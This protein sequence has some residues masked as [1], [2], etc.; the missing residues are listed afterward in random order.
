LTPAGRVKPGQ[1]KMDS[2]SAPPSLEDIRR[3]IDRIDDAVLKLIGER[4][5]MVDRVRAAKKES[6]DGRSS[7]MRPGREA[8]ILKRL[9]EASKDEI[10]A[11][12][13]FTVWRALISAATQK[14]APVRVHGPAG[15]LASASAHFMVREYFGSAGLITHADEEAAFAALADHPSDVAAMITDGPWLT[16]FL[17]GLAGKAQVIGCLPFL[18]PEPTPRVLIFG[19]STPEP[20]GDD[21]TLVVTDG[22]VPRDFAPAPLWQIE[23]G[24]KRL[25]SLPGFLSE[26]NMPLIN[27]QRSNSRLA[28]TVVG[29]YPSPIEVKS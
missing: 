2:P 12:V 7:P 24:G 3:E 17:K 27:L 6:E 20:T 28:L 5:A 13:C 29:R 10:P 15:L 19:H 11:E 26:H 14:Q 25:T 23:T 9:I 21:E 1:K 18:A 22:Q 4:L 8:G 16:P